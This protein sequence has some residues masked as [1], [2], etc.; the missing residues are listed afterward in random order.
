MSTKYNTGV[1]SSTGRGGEKRFPINTGRNIFRRAHWSGIGGKSFAF[2]EDPGVVL[3]RILAKKSAVSI[4]FD[5]EQTGKLWAGHKRDRA[6]IRNVT[7][8]TYRA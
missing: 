6:Y 1:A 3:E 2:H 4:T 7:A 5:R 8:S